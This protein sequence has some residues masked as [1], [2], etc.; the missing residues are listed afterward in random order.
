MGSTL[1]K[2]L[3]DGTIL[4]YRTHN[5]NA[6]I[7]TRTN[8]INS[9]G[10]TGFDVDGQNMTAYVWDA[11]HPLVNHQEHFDSQGN[12]RVFIKDAN[13]GNE[14]LHFHAAHVIGTIAATG[15]NANAK[16]MSFKSEVKSYD[17]D[18]D[19]A[20]AT[21]AAQDVLL[22]SNLSY[23]YD[24]SILDSWYFG[25]YIE[26]S[27]EWDELMHSAPYYL[28]VNSAGNDGITNYCQFL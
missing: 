11:G 21:A 18:N 3:P 7:S 5:K 20:E 16:G 14:Y 2:V 12:N 8:H 27:A 26:E 24:S 1:R 15:V 28:M 10:I 17:W 19:L 9:G 22:I 6:A 25:A 23:G 4:Y 13:P